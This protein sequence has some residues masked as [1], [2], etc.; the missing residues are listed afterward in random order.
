MSWTIFEGRPIYWE[1]PPEQIAITN[2]ETG[3]HDFYMLTSAATKRI[4]ELDEYVSR[5]EARLGSC[6]NLANH[7]G[8]T[9]FVC[10]ECG[11]HY[12]GFEFQYCPHCGGRISDD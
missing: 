7:M 8:R 12:L 6:R 9:E 3:E 10:S 11:A 1:E 4:R 2:V 5:L